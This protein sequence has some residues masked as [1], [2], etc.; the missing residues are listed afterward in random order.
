MKSI[1]EKI[2]ELRCKKNITQEDVAY[3]LGVSRQSVSK[4]E[5]DQAI[6]DLDKIK[7]LCEYFNVSIGYLVND[8]TDENVIKDEVI[9][10]EKNE[11]SNKI[12]RV[13]QM[14]LKTCFGFYVVYLLYIILITVFQKEVLYIFD[15]RYETFV[16]PFLYII[17]K[18]ISF[19]MITIFSYYIIKKQNSYNNSIIFNIASIFTLITVNYIIGIIFG[20]IT[21]RYIS[22]Q[23]IE[24]TMA[25][26]QLTSVYSYYGFIT[27]FA[28]Y[29][30]LFSVSADLVLRL[31][32]PEK[33]GMPVNNKPYS[34][35]CGVI[36]FIGGFLLGIL[37]LTGYIVWLIEVRKYDKDKFKKSL[38]W[39]IIGAISSI[40]F[41]IISLVIVVLSNL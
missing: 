10:N 37:F 2:Y 41:L 17:P 15:Y 40:I 4:W 18:I 5:T 24:Y 8:D 31:L 28:F 35:I 36:S 16:F 27:S 29:L 7:M 23:S 30:F 19:T 3:E 26:S 38:K 1:G 6:P 13:I 25:Y 22:N 14:C 34:T 33:Y 11:T 39:Y 21:N 32:S 20:Y 9:K 12:K